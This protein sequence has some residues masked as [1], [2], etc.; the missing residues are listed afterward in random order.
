MK[1][2]KPTD[3][4]KKDHKVI[5]DII[6]ILEACANSLEEG[7]KCDLD[8]LNG[9]MNLIKN[10]THKYHRRTEESVLFKIAEKKAAPWGARNISSM[11]REHEEGAEQVRRVADLLRESVS[12]G[13]SSKKSKK[14]VIKNIYAYSFLLGSHLMQEEKILYPMIE[15]LLASQERKNIMKSF[16][17]LNQEMME[18][19]DKER[20]VNLIKEYKKRLNI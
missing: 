19:G 12:G 11:L 1:N 4:L 2:Q 13:I 6:K 7:G 10:F 9:S 14:A 15:S 17:R 16:E 8:I 3:I 18:V 5:S 20:Y